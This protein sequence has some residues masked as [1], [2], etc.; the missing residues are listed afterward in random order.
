MDYFSFLEFIHQRNLLKVLKILHKKMGIYQEVRRTLR[1]GL[2][3]LQNNCDPVEINV[4]SKRQVIFPA[5]NPT[6]GPASD[7]DL[8]VSSTFGVFS[9]LF[10]SSDA[11]TSTLRFFFFKSNSVVRCCMQ[12]F[13]SFRC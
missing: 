10:T 9:L 3:F 6:P 12:S 7:A 1:L 11:R 13:A 4:K 5:L 2:Q 8:T